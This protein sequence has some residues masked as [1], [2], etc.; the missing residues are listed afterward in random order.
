MDTTNTKSPSVRE[1]PKLL[2]YSLIFS[3]SLHA[4]IVLILPL[5]E[6]EQ[7]LVKEQPTRVRLVDRPTVK[8]EQKQLKPSEYEID[9]PQQKTV[10]EKPVESFRKAEKEQLVTKEQAPKGTDVRDQTVTNARPQPLPVMPSTKAIKPAKPAPKIEKRSKPPVTKRSQQQKPTTVTKKPEVI[11]P[12]QEPQPT[13]PAPQLPQ[14]SPEQLFPDRQ[15]LDRIAGTSQGD[16]NRIKERDDVEIGDTIWLNLQHD[17]LVSFFRRFHD[18]VEG[19]WNYPME[20]IEREIEG[21]LELLITVNK[22]GELLDVDLKRSSGSDLLDF[23]AIQ[24]VYRAAPFGPLTK[25][26][27]HDKLNVRAYFHYNIAGKYIYGR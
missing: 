22:K 18:R 24:A 12:P 8:K 17:M 21:T 25:H 20:A 2:I 1:R 15:I 27:P 4:A 23:E 26:Y 16:R 5:F 19:V 14:F 6:P 10:P 13:R 7:P 11:V 9:Q 3:L